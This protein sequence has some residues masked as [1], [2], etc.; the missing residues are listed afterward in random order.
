MFIFLG[1]FQNSLQQT[2]ASLLDSLQPLGR[3]IAQQVTPTVRTLFEE[4]QMLATNKELSVENSTATFFKN[5]YP[6]VYQHVA[7]RK[8]LPGEF[9]Q[10][11]KDNVHVISPFENVPSTLTAFL[12]KKL[13]PVQVFLRNLQTIGHVVDAIDNVELSE[14]CSLALVKMSYCSLCDGFSD[15]KPCLQYCTDVISSC[16]EP[17]SLIEKH[18]S[19]FITRM[20]KFRN[21][22]AKS[23]DASNLFTKLQE[24]LAESVSHAS[25][26]KVATKVSMWY[27]LYKL[28]AG[29]IIF[30][31]CAI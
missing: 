31:D 19:S 3:H 25:H 30:K 22:L 8:K 12:V 18:W 4:L 9:A 16:L 1:L 28:I 7:V 27:L 21:V 2:A 20:E 23:L 15:V 11:L 10:C 26:S 13:T 6:F 29:S 5:L 17:Y 14:E 24:L